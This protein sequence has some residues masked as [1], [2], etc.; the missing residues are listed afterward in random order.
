[1]TGSFSIGLQMVIDQLNTQGVL[2]V[3][4]AGNGG[5]DY[6]SD[7][8]DY[9]PVWPANM[10]EDNVIS[11]TATDANDQL[12]GFA[13]YGPTSVDLAAPGVNILTTSLG[14]GNGWGTGTSDA[15]PFVSGTAA[16]AFAYAPNAT[17]AQVK[18]A[19]LNGTDKLPSLAGKCVSGGRLNIF[20]AL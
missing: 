19:I 7:N 8:N 2:V 5:P 11:V 6:I 13:N 1:W 18:A 4:A 14:G 17:A 10:P 3:A 20:N 9:I 15:T 16:L 12:A